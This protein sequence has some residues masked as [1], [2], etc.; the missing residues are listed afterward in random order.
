VSPLFFPGGDI[1]SL[2]VNG[3][4]NDLAMCGARPLALSVGLILEEGLPLETLRR[5]LRSMRTAADVVGVPLVTGDTKV[6]DKG[7]GDGIFINTA[8]VGIVETGIEI[9][10]Q[11]V[12]PGDAILVSGDLGRHG[13]AILSVREG[14]EFEAET[15]SDSAPLWDPVQ[16]LLSAQV[17]LRCLRDLTRGGLSSALNEISATRKVGIRIWEDSLPVHET[18]RGASEILGLDPAYIANEGRFVAFVESGD[19]ETALN[20]LRRFPIC[21]EAA[22]IGN[23]A[24]DHPGTVVLQTR[25]GGSRVLDMLKSNCPESADGTLPRVCVPQI[26]SAVGGGHLTTAD[27]KLPRRWRIK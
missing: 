24:A 15:A 16:A 22:I 23:V 1:G 26:P 2:A 18:V 11:L 8:G 3:T 10:P 5:V 17:G 13:I 12:L 25:L 4:I 19:A 14:L 27:Q 7:K 21:A 20:L 9:G 6:V